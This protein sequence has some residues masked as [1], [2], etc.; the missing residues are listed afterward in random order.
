MVVEKNGERFVEG[1]VKMEG[2][3]SEL[4]VLE[5]GRVVLEWGTGV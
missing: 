5:K 3:W 2:W 1:G 4:T